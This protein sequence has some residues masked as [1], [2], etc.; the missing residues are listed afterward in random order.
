MD[1]REWNALMSE[2]NQQER[3]LQQMRVNFGW[4]KEETGKGAEADGSRKSTSAAGRSR[5]GTS[6]G[7]TRDTVFHSARTSPGKTEASNSHGGGTISIAPGIQNH[8]KKAG[9][10][11]DRTDVPASGSKTQ[12]TVEDRMRLSADKDADGKWNASSM[13]IEETKDPV[14]DE[15]L[16]LYQIRKRYLGMSQDEELEQMEHQVPTPVSE[17]D[18]PDTAAGLHP[19]CL[20]LKIGTYLSKGQITDMAQQEMLLLS[21]TE[22]AADP[23][24][25]QFYSVFTLLQGNPSR[26][27]IANV[28]AKAGQIPSGNAVGSSIRILAEAIRN[29]VAEQDARDIS[30]NRYYRSRQVGYD[31]IHEKARKDYDDAKRRTDRW[32]K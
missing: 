21:G 26:S 14:T 24:M 15:D 19:E 4:E 12:S 23:G 31:R 5:T 18:G 8:G 10:C 7:Q 13:L 6:R 22:K 2:I 32:R 11:L 30:Q 25:K 9:N 20:F 28:L 3:A 29:A 16:Q 1:E 27:R 17:W